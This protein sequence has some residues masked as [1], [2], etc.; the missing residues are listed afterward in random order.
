M[1]ATVTASAEHATALIVALTSPVQGLHSGP[2]PLPVIVIVLPPAHE[3]QA[4]ARYEKTGCCGAEQSP[5]TRNKLEEERALKHGL[6]ASSSVT[7][8]QGPAH[9]PETIMT[10]DG[11]VVDAGRVGR[12]RRRSGQTRDHGSCDTIRRDDED[13]PLSEHTSNEPDSGKTAREEPD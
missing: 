5:R 1:W 2:N 3:R 4:H 11:A 9:G 10:G 12:A 8:A 7:A 13:T 6:E